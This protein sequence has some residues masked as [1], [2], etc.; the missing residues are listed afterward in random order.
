MAKA[1]AIAVTGQTI[2]G[3]LADN[4]PKS[5][6]AN[7]R[8]ELYQTAN[9]TTSP[10]EEGISLFLYRVEVNSSL[11]NLPIKTGLD[12][13]TRRP[14]LPLDLYYL[15]TVWAKDAVKQQ[16]ILGWA[17]RTLEDS[18]VLSAGRLNHFGT[19]TDVFQPNETVEII[20]QTMT[21]Q[22]LSNLWSAFK[23]SVPVSVAYIARVIGIDSTI[24]AEQSAP[25]QTRELDFANI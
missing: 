24:S 21:L 23:V 3:L 13:I 2:L 20:F 7:A 18:P 5:E 8:F 14:P 6:F 12:G 9:F 19:E 10:M 1:Q 4:I 25:V 11:R 16:R 15:L 17:M 22:D